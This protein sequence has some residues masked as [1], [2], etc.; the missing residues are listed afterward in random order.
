[1]RFTRQPRYEAYQWTDRKKAAH[2]KRDARA[3]ARVER[4]Y[5]LFVEE[6]KPAPSLSVED[7]GARREHLAKQSEQSMRDLSAKHWRAARRAYFACSKEVRAAIRAAWSSWTGPLNA[8]NFSY[9]VRKHNGELE[10]LALQMRQR[11]AAMRER[12]Y[13]QFSAQADL[14]NPVEL[15]TDSAPCAG[16]TKPLAAHTTIS[17]DSK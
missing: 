14:L 15:V 8:G 10:Q 9:V 12:I 1:M 6:F 5:P 11:D 3:Q 17:G 4:D 13:A 2:L 7:E 16:Y